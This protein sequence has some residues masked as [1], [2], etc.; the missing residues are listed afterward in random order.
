MLK[1]LFLIVIA[2]FTVLVI[3]CTG[4]SGSQLKTIQMSVP[5]DL[6]LAV[7]GSENIMDPTLFS[8]TTGV[9]EIDEN[10]LNTQ[11]KVENLPDPPAGYSYQMFV[12]TPDDDTNTMMTNYVD[13]MMGSDGEFCN[14]DMAD[15]MESMMNTTQMTEIHEVMITLINDD[16]S[17]DDPGTCVILYGIEDSTS[18]PETTVTSENLCSDTGMMGTMGNNMM[19]SGN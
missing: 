16:E 3:G 18:T 10:S 6:N 12:T 15:T 17:T 8:N 13:S 19:G 1:T 11:L 4:N 7:S 9:F 2:V 5:S 14:S